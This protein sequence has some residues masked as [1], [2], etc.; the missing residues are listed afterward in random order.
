MR[1][2]TRNFRNQGIRSKLFAS[3]VIVISIPFILLLAIHISVTQQENKDAAIY[4][5]QKM[6]AETAAY[7]QYKS[8]NIEEVMNSIALNEQI[9]QAVL[10]PSDPFQ[11]VNAWHMESLRLARIIKQSRY[12]NDINQIQIFMKEGLASATESPDYLRLSRITN[13]TW[14]LKF[15]QSHAIFIWLPSLQILP[16]TP[17]GELTVLRKLPNEHNVR[18][19]DAILSATIAPRTMQSVLNHAALTPN[20]SALLFNDGGALLSR[21]DNAYFSKEV[22]EQLHFLVEN[23]G[24]EMTYYNTNYVLNQERYLVGIKAIPHTDMR[25]VL[26]IP[27]K[28]ILETTLKARNRIISIFLIVVPLMIPVSL[29]V[30]GSATKRIRQ[31]IIHVR[32]IRR[33]QFHPLPWS[34]KPDEIAEL[35]NSFNIM[36][37]DISQLI[38]D[39]YMLG[40]EVKHKELLALQAQINPHFLYNT[41]ELINAM[42]IESNAPEIQRVVDELAVFYRISLSNG[43]EFVR[44]ENELKHIEAYVRIQNM[45]F[46]NNIRLELEVSKEFYDYKLPRIILQ[47][48]VEN[49]ILHGIM[50]K[51]DEEGCIRV[52]ARR[53]EEDVVIEVTDDGVGMDVE[54]VVLLMHQDNIYKETGGYGIRNVEE[55]LKLSY[56][57]IYGMTFKSELG[58]GTS[59][60]IRLPKSHIGT[61]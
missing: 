26:L 1:R 28:D 19:T 10:S 20:A 11:N 15:S 9:Q 55:R 40:R 21:T 47:P 43:Q 50:E 16:N 30:A 45:R 4:S 52:T 14:F 53:E 46:G 51:D 58:K 34:T 8:E 7:I 61:R 59:I 18:D 38:E 39:K 60:Q 42:A 13:E 56:G 2:L 54:T 33:G 31:L 44:L 29:I 27:Y 37:H 5:S 32:K 24:N 35:T 17:Q 57:N 48:L 41:L 3:Y 49:A 12:T 36:V 6:L 23:N 22:L 25:I